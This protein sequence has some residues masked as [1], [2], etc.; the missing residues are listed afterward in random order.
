MK[1]K[2]FKKWCNERAQDGCWSVPTAAFCCG[3]M[4]L[5]NT[6]PFWKREKV[7]NKGYKE[8][9]ENAIVKPITKRLKEIQDEQVLCKESNL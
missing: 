6:Y 4:E 9:V 5:I 8:C 7:W 3:L 1:Y 2:E